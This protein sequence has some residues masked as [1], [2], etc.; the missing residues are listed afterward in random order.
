LTTKRR[1]TSFDVARKAGVSRSVV[2]A[3]LNGT[4][5]I[6]VSAETRETVLEAI[7]ELGYEVNAQARA[8]KTGISHC[9]AVR[10]NTTNPMFLQA[11]EGIQEVC[12]NAGYHVLLY[13]DKSDDSNA[14]NGL[15]NL[16]QQRR[17]DGIIT[18]DQA[19]ESD[20]EWARAVEEARVP[21]VSIE[22]Y[23]DDETVHSVN[24]DY[25]RS[26]I[27]ALDFMREHGAERSIY[28]QFLHHQDI[29]SGSESERREAYEAWMLAHREQPVLQRLNVEDESTLIGFIQSWREQGSRPYVLLNWSSEL[30]RFMRAAN[31]LGLRIGDDYK[32]MA[33]DNTLRVNRFLLPAVAC[34]EIPYVSMGKLAGERLLGLLGSGSAARQEEDRKMRVLATL[35]EGESL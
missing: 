28:V 19:G 14:R 29:E 3:V 31:G 5:G 16:Y 33:L 13:G 25:R 17:I 22:G 23:P 35:F 6:G 11:L 21:Y 2:S 27:D 9:I 26:V 1:A 20:D 4:P 34:M 7:R 32:L 18:L 15:L 10:G 12:V 24:V 8:M 30:N